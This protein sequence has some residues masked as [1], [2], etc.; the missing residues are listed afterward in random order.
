MFSLTAAEHL[1][2]GVQVLGGRYSVQRTG[3]YILQEAALP[4]G[5]G[6]Y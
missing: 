1:Q 4:E 2:I 3:D 5:H 6:K